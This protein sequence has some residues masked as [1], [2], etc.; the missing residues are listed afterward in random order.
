MW[1]AIYHCDDCLLSWCSSIDPWAR[2]L[3]HFVL[4]NRLSVF[5]FHAV[6]FT[7]LSFFSESFLYSIPTLSFVLS[8]DLFQFPSRTHFVEP[9]PIVDY[10]IT[11]AVANF[12]TVCHF[13]SCY[14]SVRQNQFTYMV[15][16]VIT[17]GRA[18]TSSSFMD[19]TCT[20]Y[21]KF[22]YPLVDT[23]RTKHYSY[24]I[25]EVSNKYWPQT[26]PQTIKN[27]LPYT[28]LPWYKSRHSLLH[29]K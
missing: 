9:K 28:A 7:L 12:R 15:G 25:Q 17:C 8:G 6:L 11:R 19:D 16:I 3:Y 14:L 26:H 10:F 2:K 13:I 22:L 24:A 1:Q 23:S 27:K 18:R 5:T 20:I 4:V 29:F 21:L